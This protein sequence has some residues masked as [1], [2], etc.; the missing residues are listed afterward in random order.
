M[1]GH[2]ATPAKHN[3]GIGS[4]SASKWVRSP[5]TTDSSSQVLGIEQIPSLPILSISLSRCVNDQTVSFL[6]VSEGQSRRNGESS[7][8][9]YSFDMF[10]F[11]AEPHHLY[12]HC[13]VQLCEPDDLKSCK[14]VS[15]LILLSY[16]VDLRWRYDIRSHM[17][18]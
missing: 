11:T 12:L 5:L 1:L 9:R 6:N 15:S 8:V 10:R 17:Y 18:F 4:H 13:T 7:T 2:T 3:R 16:M 14:P